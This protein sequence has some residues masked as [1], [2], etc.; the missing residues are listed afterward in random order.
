MPLND[1]EAIDLLR[2]TIKAERQASKGQLQ[3][4][5]QA[6]ELA[7]R[8]ISTLTEQNGKLTCELKTT[9]KIAALEKKGHDVARLREAFPEGMIPDNP[10]L[11]LGEPDEPEDPPDGNRPPTKEERLTAK[12]KASNCEEAGHV[13]VVFDSET[14]S[15]GCS[16]CTCQVGEASL[17]PNDRL[18]LG[19]VGRTDPPGPLSSTDVLDPLEAKAR[20]PPGEGE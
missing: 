8:A 12:A 13:F 2:A 5:V 18:D 20:Q 6:L 1:D 4:L 9:T 15:Y 7:K 19:L 3:A 14:R 17:R 16:K 11:P 10:S